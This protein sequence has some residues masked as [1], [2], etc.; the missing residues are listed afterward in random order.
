MAAKK[1]KGKETE[2]MKL[3]YL[4]YTQERWDN[5]IA[6]L[7]E[8]NFEQDPESDEMPE[9]MQ[10]LANFTEDIN[11]E[12]L[13]IIRLFQND[14]FSREEALDKVNEVEEIIMG[15]APEGDIEDIIEGIQLPL[16]ALFMGCKKYLNEEF[17][18]EVKDLVK[19]GRSIVDEDVEKALEIAGT[20]GALV[21][22]GGSCCGRYLRDD[23]DNPSLFD[24]WLIEIDTMGTALKSL[25]K[26]DEE[27]GDSS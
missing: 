14:R 27:P 12:V 21:I 16:L 13:K 23:M 20:I 22:N 24:E 17:E 15:A 5:W 8:M 1:K 10:A 2:P 26:F 4:F 11:V 6:T 7:Q 18:G 19:Q 25:K 9:G 3:F